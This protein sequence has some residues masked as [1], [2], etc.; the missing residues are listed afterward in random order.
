MEAS[1]C[2]CQDLLVLVVVMTY[3]SKRILWYVFQK[4]RSYRRSYKNKTDQSITPHY[5]SMGILLFWSACSLA[6]VPP[7]V[8]TF[9]LSRSAFPSSVMIIFFS[10]FLWIFCSIF[11]SYITSLMKNTLYAGL[12][13][14]F[15]IV[16]LTELLRVASI[17][18]FMFVPSIL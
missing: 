7:I 3:V 1:E 13:F 15:F 14:L 8:T 9:V 17:S 12:F 11:L 2:L 18:F 10:S 6:L 4:T 16:V 5:L